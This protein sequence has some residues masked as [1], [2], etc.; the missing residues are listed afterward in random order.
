[1]IDLHCHILPG[2]DDGPAT[3]EDAVAL[4]R[5]LVADG[6]TTVA[7]TPHLRSDHR[8]VIVSELRERCAQLQ[9]LLDAREIPL[10]V[11]PGGEVD[12]LWALRASRDD[13][14]LACYGDLAHDL[15]LETP[16][17][18]LPAAFA[19]HVQELI[20]DGFRVLLAHPERNQAFREDPDAIEELTQRGVLVQLTADSLTAGRGHA[21]IARTSRR[22]I[23]RGTAHV[24]SSDLHGL[25][26]ARRAPLSAAVEAASE[27]APERA[28]WMVTRAPNA[29]LEGRSLDPPP[30]VRP[31][32]LVRRVARRLF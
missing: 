26:T 31:S 2:I 11:A 18:P 14:E 27:I 17:G 12:L 8:G 5:A 23:A 6:T 32:G 13:L 4:A 19:N 10:R 24:I 3:A 15:L 30:S 20:D 7:A 29:I 16:Y 22:W 25:R 1:M 9:G 21:S 28:R